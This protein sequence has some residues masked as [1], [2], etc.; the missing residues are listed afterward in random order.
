MAEL[1][2]GVLQK[3]EPRV[4]TRMYCITQHYSLMLSTSAIVTLYFYMFEICDFVLCC[5]PVIVHCR[6]LLAGGR[7]HQMP[8]VMSFVHVKRYTPIVAI[9]LLVSWPGT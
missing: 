8:Q 2:R 1:Y 5:V 6:Y 9:M 4:L 3:D 7:Y